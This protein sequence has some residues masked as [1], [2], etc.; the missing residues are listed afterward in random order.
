MTFEEVTG[1]AAVVE[2][3]RHSLVPRLS[4]AAGLARK[5]FQNLSRVA[6]QVAVRRLVYPSGVEKLDRVRHEVLRDVERMRQR[7]GY[8]AAGVD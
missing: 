8:S 5:R 2:L 1:A 7:S 6:L 4:A 3:L